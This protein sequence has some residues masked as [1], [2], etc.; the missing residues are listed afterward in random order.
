MSFLRH[1]EP[2]QVNERFINDRLNER[3][4]Y[5]SL[6]DTVLSLILMA[7]GCLAKYAPLTFSFIHLSIRSTTSSFAFVIEFLPHLHYQLTPPHRFRFSAT[8]Y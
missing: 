2:H 6:V 4:R 8:R 5:V 1:K 7:S 3:A